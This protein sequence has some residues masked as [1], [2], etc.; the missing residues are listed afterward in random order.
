MVMCPAPK[1]FNEVMKE[2]LKNA[3]SVP[4]SNF[5]SKTVTTCMPLKDRD[6]VLERAMEIVNSNVRNSL[7]GTKETSVP[8]ANQRFLLE[9]A[10][11]ERTISCTQNHQNE[12]KDSAWRQHDLTPHFE[13]LLVDFSNVMWDPEEERGLDAGTILALRIAF[14]FFVYH[15]YTLD[16]KNFC[17]QAL[18]YKD[19]FK[20]ANVIS[21]IRDDLHL[22][23]NQYLSLF[24]HLDEIQLIFSSHWDGIPERL[25]PIVQEGTTL[26]GIPPPTQSGLS[27]FKDMMALLGSYMI[28]IS[29]YDFVQTFISGTARTNIIESTKPTSYSIVPLNCPMLSMKSCFDIMRY[30]M[31]EHVKVEDSLWVLC[32]WI[33]ELLSDTGG[34]PRAMQFLLERCFGEGFQRAQEFLKEIKDYASKDEIFR[35]VATRLNSQYHIENFALKNRQLVIELIH[36]CISRTPSR[37]EDTVP[38]SSPLRTFEE[39]ESE[40]HTIL[41]N[42]NE[43]QDD[44]KVQVRIPFLFL[45]LYNKALCDVKDTLQN[46]FVSSW[47]GRWQDWEIICAEYAVYRTEIITELG[48]VEMTLGEFFHGAYGQLETLKLPIRLR[49]LQLIHAE[50]RFPV[51]PLTIDAEKVDWRHGLVVVNADGASFADIFFY[52]ENTSRNDKESEVYHKLISD[53]VEDN[54]NMQKT[55]SITSKHQQT[56]FNNNKKDII[57]MLQSK[58]WFQPITV[59]NIR[60]EHDKNLHAIENSP[61]C[62]NLQW[63]R[64]VTIVL[65]TSEFKGDCREIPKDCLLICQENFSDYF[66]DP[67]S[68]RVVLSNMKNNNPN[69]AS[70]ATLVAKHK[71]P[72]NLAHNIVCKRPF[73]SAEHLIKEIPEMKV[74]S[75][76]LNRMQY[77]PNG[78]GIDDFNYPKRRRLS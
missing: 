13:Y 72:H 11:W 49:K 59:E 77:F 41:E 10:V 35:D 57:A 76:I 32:F 12:R 52:V 67:F 33:Y 69:F 45:Y 17:H 47:T 70:A 16:F 38:N 1:S 61:L 27:L 56:S 44:N 15:S 64:L 21:G 46:T 48:Q 9:N 75:D 40:M 50:H 71:F 42:C 39:L 54:I 5:T 8:K 7:S 18:K 6:V 58:D 55:R 74:Y 36:R 73:D 22:P 51:H 66:G 20:F 25:K 28:G 62:N 30:F 29:Q 53:K 24:L 23:D 78:V 19:F 14:I 65:A 37:R 4:P 3:R 31:K 60:E 43:H 2:I 26:P 34:L 68:A 63:Y